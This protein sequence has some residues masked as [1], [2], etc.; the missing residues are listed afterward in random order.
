MPY[1]YLTF[2]D[3]YEEEVRS[4]AP[5]SPVM[6]ASSSLSPVFLLPSPSPSSSHDTSSHP[7]HAYLHPTR[8]HSQQRR[9]RHTRDVHGHAMLKTLTQDSD[10][11]APAVSYPSSRSSS[12]ATASSSTHLDLLRVF[13]RKLSMSSSSKKHTAHA[14]DS[15]ALS[16]PTSSR[17]SSFTS[18]G[19]ASLHPV[20]AASSANTSPAISR[21]VTKN[22]SDYEAM[23]HHTARMEQQEEA[24]RQRE[25][26]EYFNQAAQTGLSLR[27]F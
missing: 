19:F 18:H 13:K 7:H 26:Q 22:F 27:R 11:V 15:S 2:S 24:T 3:L 9:H 16:T 5:S 8:S 20:S 14:S 21:Q 25:L 1:Q 12:S 17:R 6:G 23:V 10:D 4:S